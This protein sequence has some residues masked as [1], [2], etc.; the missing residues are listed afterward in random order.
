MAATHLESAIRLAA[1][2]P[3]GR[4]QVLPEEA[5]VDVAATMEVEQGRDGRRLGEV[6]LALSLG[7]RL[8]RAVE[9]VDIG[10]VVLGVVQ[11][12]DLARDVRLEGTVVV[13]TIQSVGV[14][15][16][17]AGIAVAGGMQRTYTAGPEG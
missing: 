13:C 10:L 1:T 2:L 8:E 7:N 4:G 17:L 3:A 9:A 12:H 16:T 11:L 15:A 14:Q 5:V 6:A